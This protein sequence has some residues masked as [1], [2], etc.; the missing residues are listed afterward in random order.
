VEYDADAFREFEASGWE[1]VA[2][3]YAA[4]D[5]VRDLTGQAG[6]AMAR[7]VGASPGRRILDVACGPGLASRAARELGADVVGVD[8]AEAMVTAAERTVPDGQFRQAAAEQLPF[9]A[10]S[11][12]GA[13][14][15]FGLP[16]FADPDAVLSETARV[17]KAGGQMAFTTWCAPEKVPFFGLVF[18]AVADHGTFEIDLP[19][20]PDMFRFGDESEAA[21]TLDRLG[22]DDVTVAELALTVELQTAVQAMDLVSAATVRTRALFEAQTPSA[23]AAIADSI[24]AATEAMRTNGRLVVPMPAVLISATR[25]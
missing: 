25:P 24:T 8:I 21:N 22:F 7:V 20:G 5:V 12:D 4:S 9:E 6:E 3:S 16:H 14:C 17:L 2:D 1:G 18:T 19:E 15:G 11:F 23:R 13:M 10:D